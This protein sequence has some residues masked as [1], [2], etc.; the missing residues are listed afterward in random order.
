MLVALPVCKV[1]TAVIRAK[2]AH[3]Q[4]TQTQEPSARLRKVGNEQRLHTT[5][6]FRNLYNWLPRTKTFP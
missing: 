2:A 1:A 4:I 3:V 5:W 6:Q